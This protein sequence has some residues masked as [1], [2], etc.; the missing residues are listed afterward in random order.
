[1]ISIPRKIEIILISII[2]IYLLSFTSINLFKIEYN[3]P[4]YNY[5][6]KNWLNSP[7]KNI[8]IS[9]KALS[10]EEIINE[11]DNQKNLGFFKSAS[12]KQDLDIFMNT[13]FKIELYKPYYYPNFVGFFHNKNENKICGKDTQGNIMYFPK[14]AE[15][16]INY[17]SLKKIV[18]IIFVII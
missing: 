6:T 18:I 8:E 15:C 9:Q 12:Q 14:N 2:S 10:N 3:D 1:M 16:P 5:L 7:I 17:I 4:P 11:Y 13:Y